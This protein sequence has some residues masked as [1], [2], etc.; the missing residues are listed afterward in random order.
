MSMVETLFVNGTI[1]TVEDVVAADAV[2][3]RDDRIIAVGTEAQ[4]RAAS[5]RPPEVIDLDGGTM[6]PGFVDAHCHPLM[7]G[8]FDSWVDCSWNAAPSVEDVVARLQEQAQSQRTGPVRGEGF[9]HG[10]VAEGRMLTLTD[11]DRVASDREVLVFHSSGHGAIVNS[12][13][14]Q[15]AGVTEDTPD[16]D[17]GHFGRDGSGALNGEVWDAAADVLTGAGGVKIANNGPN[18]HLPEGLAELAD[19]LGEAQSRFLSAGVT[20]VVDAQVT[21]RELRAYFALRRRGELTMRVEMLVISSLL[22]QMEALGLGDRLGDD[23]LAFSG[24]KLYVDGALTGAT[25]RFSEPYCCSTEDFGY[26]YHSPEEISELIARADRLGLQTATHAQGDAAIEVVI[27]AHEVIRASGGRTDARHRIEHFGAPTSEQVRRVQKLGLWPVT[28]PQYMRRYGEE[29]SKALGDR[30]QR[31]CPLGEM[32]DNGV[33]LVL[34][35]DAPVCPP[36]P[37]EAVC[38]AVAR[39]T[40]TGEVLGGPELRLTVAEAIEAHT[41]GA[42]RSIHRESSV[43]S[44]AA[45]KLA[46]L[47]VLSADP[48]AVAPEALMQIEVLETWVGGHRVF[49]QE[50][51]N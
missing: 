9:H 18:F 12:W 49:E 17:G 47:I 19:H 40:S 44:I 15:Q 34:S 6:L 21:A 25:A 33:P 43:G 27:D 26:Y 2:L 22:D 3:V 39:M 30:A 8:Q 20:T 36:D 35:S 29:L 38:T 11:L 4:C 24:I 48:Y 50:R 45:G 51:G 7:L 16:P 1:R 14:L 5:L 23:L 41:L 42:A 37:M 10:N 28:Q 46:D 31:L 32:R 13:V